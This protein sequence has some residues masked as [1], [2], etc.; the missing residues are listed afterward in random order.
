L[1][2]RQAKAAKRTKGKLKHW[3]GFQAEKARKCAPNGDL[4][5]SV[6]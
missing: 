2:P 4:R 1:L 6:L 5:G 3:R